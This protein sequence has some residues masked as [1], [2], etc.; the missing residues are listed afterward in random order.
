MG[1]LTLTMLFTAIVGVVD[2][3]GP[4]GYYHCSD[5]PK[6][7]RGYNDLSSRCYCALL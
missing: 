2:V 3:N 6:C 4:C 7:V 5:G 1:A